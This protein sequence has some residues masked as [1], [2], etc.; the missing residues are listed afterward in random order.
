MIATLIPFFYKIFFSLSQFWSSFSFFVPSFFISI[1]YFCSPFEYSAIKI[2][3]SLTLFI[4]SLFRAFAQKKNEKQIELELSAHL[5]YIIYNMRHTLN[6]YNIG[7][8]SRRSFWSLACVCLCFCVSVVGFL[9]FVAMS[10]PTFTVILYD[11]VTILA[12]AYG[13]ICAL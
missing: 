10:P 8:D 1:F 9:L 6:I 3:F 2:F 4:L 11:K 5:M 12:N 13:Y 7:I